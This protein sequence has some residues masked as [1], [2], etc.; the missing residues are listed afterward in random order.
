MSG[1]RST[2]RE[3]AELVPWIVP[4][5]VDHD[6][7]AII[8]MAPTKFAAAIVAGAY[9]HALAPDRPTWF[10]VEPVAIP[11]L[12]PVPS[13]PTSVSK[14][15]VH[16]TENSGVVVDAEVYRRAGLELPDFDRLA[17]I[18]DSGPALVGAGR[19][20]ATGALRRVFDPL[21]SERSDV[22]RV[23]FGHRGGLAA[24]YFE[25]DDG[26]TWI[27]WLAGDGRVRSRPTPSGRFAAPSDVVSA[28]G[29]AGPT[30]AALA[31]RSRFVAWELETAA[32]REPDTIAPS[33]EAD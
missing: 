24:V 27:G 26:R 11:E 16:G 5:I 10:D 17:R 7:T 20:R 25:L 6:P 14:L 4:A 1:C 22:T 12:G 28:G 3:R 32:Q 15:A 2:H 23:E 18:L 31:L 33:A 9:H 8:A 21:A 30:V 19:R 13:I 29:R